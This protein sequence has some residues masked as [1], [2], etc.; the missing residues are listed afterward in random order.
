MCGDITVA[1]STVSTFS[2]VLLV[3][4][5]VFY[6][7]V[8]RIVGDSFDIWSPLLDEE[9]FLELGFGFGSDTRV[10]L[11]LVDQF[12]V[13]VSSGL[14]VFIPGFDQIL[15]GLFSTSSSNFGRFVS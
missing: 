3:C 12:D 9:R 8:D 14:M 10:G 2:F 11:G 1:L 13:I 4:Y 6:I 7:L 5:V 15:V